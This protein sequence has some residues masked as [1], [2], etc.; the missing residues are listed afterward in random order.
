MLENLTGAGLLLLATTAV[1]DG[2]AELVATWLGDEIGAEPDGLT[3]AGPLELGATT[4]DEDGLT[5]PVAT[6]LGDDCTGEET[7]AEFDLTGAGLLELGA[8]RPVEDGFT[9]GAALP[10]LGTARV[11]ETGEDGGGAEATDEGPAE[12][13]A[14][15]RVLEL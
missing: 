13:A 2:L 6:W 11:D 5:E 7:G 10:V 15:A 3:G 4:A 8:T 9:E 12:L 14:E 1:E